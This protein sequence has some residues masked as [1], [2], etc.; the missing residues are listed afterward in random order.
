MSKEEEPAALERDGEV[1]APPAIRG[2]LKLRIGGHPLREVFAQ[3]H[4][5]IVSLGEK[6][7]SVAANIVANGAKRQ[8]HLGDAELLQLALDGG[9]SD[10]R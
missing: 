4:G 7:L 5:A 1:P 9:V 2:G 8:I 3:R 6:P 10:R